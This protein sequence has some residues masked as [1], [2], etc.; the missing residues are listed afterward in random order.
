MDKNL[1]A[2]VREYK[3]SILPIL[4]RLA[5]KV[6]VLG[7]HHVLKNLPLYEV[8]CAADAKACQDQLEQ[9]NKKHYVRR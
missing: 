1:L 8:V 5:P 6:L 9:K 7:K 3:L 4:P 2:M